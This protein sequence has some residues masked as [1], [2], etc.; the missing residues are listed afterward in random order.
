VSLDVLRDPLLLAIER[1]NDHALGLRGGVD[2]TP[3]DT[4]ISPPVLSPRETEVLTLMSEGLRNREIAQSLFISEVTVKA[5]V[6]S[7]FG[8]LGVRTRTEAAIAAKRSA[9]R[10]SSESG[11]SD[12]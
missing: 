5:H 6:R 9:R 2:T 12:G 4:I 7:I 11:H 10:N 8:K 3:D 1:A